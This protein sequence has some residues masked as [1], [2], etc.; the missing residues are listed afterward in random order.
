MRL[1]VVYSPIVYCNA[2]YLRT[3]RV[4]YTYEEEQSRSLIKTNI[5]I[6]QT[7]ANL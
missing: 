7:W 6:T 1:N 3:L 4:Q 2:R 5:L